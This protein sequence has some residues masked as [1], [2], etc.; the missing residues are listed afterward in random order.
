MTRVVGIQFKGSGKIYSFDC[1][2]LEIA[3]G[4]AVVV[5]TVRGKELGFAVKACYDAYEEDFSKE[6]KPVLRIASEYDLERYR[7]NIIKASEALKTCKELVDKHN[8]DMKV[9]DSSYTF[10]NAKLLFYF[11]AE[12]RIDFRDL[13]KDLASKYKTRIELRQIGVRDGAKL[14]G[15]LG[16]C[17]EELCCCRFLRD[18]ENVTIRMAKDQ[19]LSL[20]PAKISG[21]CGRLMCCLTYEQEVY[22][23]KLETLPK[24]KEIV[25][26]PEGEGKVVE[27]YPIRD[28]VK[29]QIEKKDN[30]EYFVFK[31][32]DIVFEN[33]ECKGKCACPHKNL[34]VDK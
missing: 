9:I 5:E 17:G 26:T 15:G 19:G 31:K 16:P 27:R 25:K 30:F 8:L 4:E 32:E 23:E 13:V 1:N 29:V 10:D 14:L 34:E 28:E 18:F 6:L 20:T 21:M 12:G 24:L 3:K 11:N 22:E 7:E 33:K 2:G